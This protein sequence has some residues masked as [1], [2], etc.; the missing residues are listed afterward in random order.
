MS[1]LS[2]KEAAGRAAARFVENGMRIGLGT[3]STAHWFIVAVAEAVRSGVHVEAVATSEASAGLAAELGIELVEL[4]GSGLDLAVDGADLVDP[5]L[6]LVKGGGGA[7]VRERM[8]AAA[9]RR[10]IV[11]VDGS[12]LV[13]QLRGPVPVEILHFGAGATLAALETCGAPFRLRRDGEGVPR[14]SD[15]GN[16]LADGRFG[17]ISDPEAL[18][19]RIDAVPG[20]VGHGLFLGMADRVI[21]GDDGGGVRELTAAA[22]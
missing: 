19:R 2:G 15:N 17:V 11:V 14:L 6:R 1:S 13:P 7:H 22:G 3:G 16:L 9:A 18:A 8:V 12:K 4:D 20:T 10:F 5:Q 21:V